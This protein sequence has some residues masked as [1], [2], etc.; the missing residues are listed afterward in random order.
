LINARDQI[1]SRLAEHF[2]ASCDGEAVSRGLAAAL[3]IC[4]HP[5][6]PFTALRD[7]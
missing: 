5:A 6:L 1:D 7:H 3:G 4:G 2:V